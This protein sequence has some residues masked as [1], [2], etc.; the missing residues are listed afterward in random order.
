MQAS[1]HLDELSFHLTF[2]NL[3]CSWHRAAKKDVNRE[4]KWTFG[5]YLLY[6]TLS[7]TITIRNVRSFTSAHFLMHHI[8]TAACPSA[9]GS[10]P[11]AH[12]ILPE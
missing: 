6:W 11:A 5:E 2:P 4:M 3:Y 10:D 8:W 7:H 12:T 1:I 9:L